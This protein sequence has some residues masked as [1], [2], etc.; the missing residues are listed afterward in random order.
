MD[1]T[2]IRLSEEEVSLAKNAEIILTKNA[3]MKKMQGLMEELQSLHETELTG[4]SFLPSEVRRQGPKISRGENYLGLPY[5]VLDQPRC[6]EI[7]H[8]FAIRILFWWGR[9]F[10]LT[11]HLSGRHK[12]MF[13]ERL[14]DAYDELAAAGFHFCINEDQWMHHLEADNYISLKD[15]TKQ[16]VDKFNA[17]KP[18]LKLAK[19]IE[20]GDINNTPLEIHES[21]LFVLDVLEGK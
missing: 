18:F 10:I 19:R 11:L 4:R 15:S 2:K 17:S 3:V 21:F 7:N 6:F 16:E 9:S 1:A 20:L 8:I 5:L 13:E 14:L 12:K